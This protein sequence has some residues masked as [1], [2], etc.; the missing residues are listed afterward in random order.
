MEAQS[1]GARQ[2]RPFALPRPPFAPTPPAKHS[3]FLREQMSHR[4]AH[5]QTHRHSHAPMPRET[6]G[7]RK[8]LSQSQSTWQRPG[9]DERA[10]GRLSEDT[11]AEIHEDSETDSKTA[12]GDT[13]THT[14]THTHLS[15]VFG[16]TSVPSCWV[17]PNFDMTHGLRPIRLLCPWHFPGE[18]TGVGWHFLLR[19]IFP[20]Q[21]S[22]P[23]LLRV[24][25]LPSEPGHC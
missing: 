2:P 10:G 22:N 16:N 23:S 24:D 21:G 17:E 4:Q 18:N 11:E 20:T 15:V 19:G 12:R 8:L 14:H 9:P 7:L 5:R 3:T 6:A 1:T 13:Q 25:A